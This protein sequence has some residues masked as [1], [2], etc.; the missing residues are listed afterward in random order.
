MIVKALRSWKITQGLIDN[1]I[2]L[3]SD[4]MGLSSADDEN[5]AHTSPT[6]MSLAAEERRLASKRC[7]IAYFNL[8]Q[9]EEL[10]RKKEP[11]L[12]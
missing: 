5:N 2:L 7:A 12:W 8:K 11:M 4:Y 3:V 9:A 10:P 1:V 6:R